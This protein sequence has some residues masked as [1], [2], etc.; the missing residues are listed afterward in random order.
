M[1]S[2]ARQESPE[3][4]TRA[5]VLIAAGFLVFVALSLAVLRVYY[6]W[7]VRAPVLSP[8][9]TF[10]E[11]RLQSD[12]RTDRIGLQAE[13]E[14]QLAGYA[15]V[16]RD[17]GLARIPIERAMTLIAGRGERAFAPIDGPETPRQGQP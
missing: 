7:S 8:P 10:A 3:V 15:W 2:K 9:S 12:P 6:G 16:D 11:P 5:V 1:P 14:K 4:A 17:R 13:Q